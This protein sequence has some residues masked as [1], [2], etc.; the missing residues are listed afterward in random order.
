M[1]YFASPEI[2]PVVPRDTS[3]SMRSL[4]PYV[5]PCVSMAEF[6]HMM[7]SF[8]AEPT[9]CIK[10]LD[11]GR[12][13]RTSEKLTTLP[14]A[15]PK[16]IRPPEVVVYDDSEGRAGSVWS[17]SADIWA[18]GCTI[19]QIY[20]KTSYELISTWGS[21][22]DF[23]LRT[24]QLG[25]P[26][27]DAWPGI[28][29]T[30]S[31]HGNGTNNGDFCSRDEAWRNQE[32][33]SSSPL[34]GRKQAFIDLLKEMIVTNPDGRTPLADLLGH[35][36]FAITNSETP[37]PTKDVE[38]VRQ[39]NFFFP[40][41]PMTVSSHLLL[42]H[43]CCDAYPQFRCLSCRSSYSPFNASFFARRTAATASRRPNSYTA[44]FPTFFPRSARLDSTL[45]DRPS[46]RKTQKDPTI[47]TT[48]VELAL[49][50]T[51]DTPGTCIYVHHEK[52]SYVFGQV[53]EGTQRA[54]SCRKLHLGG[55]EHVFLSG[56]VRWSQMGGL[57]GYLLSVGGAIDSAKEARATMN[58]E[59]AEKGQKLLR[60]LRNEGV[61]VH[62]ADNLSHI[63]AS[64]RPTIFR[65][66]IDVRVI[67]FR[68]DPRAADSTLTAPDWEDESIRVWKI[69]VRRA[70]S[71][72]PTKRPRSDSASSGSCKP[73]SE[74]SDPSVAQWILEKIM[75]TGA[76][77]N[78]ML[79]SKSIDELKPDDDAIVVEGNR[80]RR[81]NGPFG[82][83]APKSFSGSAKAWV[84][85]DANSVHPKGDLIGIN[86]V[87]NGALP[88]TSYSETS[89]SYI[90]KCHDRRGKF[91]AQ[92]A[93]DLGVKP[94]SFKLLTAGET[95]TT[96]SGTVVTP[97]MVL[98][99]R[100]PG[101]GIAVADIS[102]RDFL[103]AFFERP[104]WTNAEIMAEVKTMYWVLG[105]GIVAD[106]KIQQYIKAHPDIKHVLCSPNTCPNMISNSSSA[107]TLAKLRRVDPD[108]F[109]F[110]A[111]DN[112]VDY[113][114]PD[115]VPSLELGRTGHRSQLMPRLL[116]D[117]GPVASFTDLQ[118][119][120]NAVDQE[121]IE[122]AQ[123]AKAKVTDPAFLARIERQEA[124]IPNRDAEITALGTGS[125]VPNKHRNV[126]GTLIRVPGIGSYLLDCGEG[127]LGQIKRLFGP[128][129]TAAVLRDLR[130]IVVS[131][132]HADHHLGMAS[133]IK[134]WYEQ[135]LADKSDALLAVSCID[136]YRAVL[137]EIAQ[138]E[139]I[140]FH[141]LRFPSCVGPHRDVTT[142]EQLG[143]L[144][145]PDAFGLRR[146]RRVPVPHCWRSYATE[147]ELV[148]GLRIAWSGDCR[149]SSQFARACRGA[150][151][152]VHE[153][154]FGDDK[155][156]HAK[157]K[158]HSTMSEALGVAREMQARRT[159]L[160][161]F[162]QR[163]GKAD[164]LQ[165]IIE[166][167]ARGEE[168]EQSV[169]LAH[170]LMRVKLG[171]FQ[172]AACYVPAIAQVLAKTATDA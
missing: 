60:Q 153:C 74:P 160:T 128:K 81:Y 43:V 94:Q 20:Y 166:G 171:D 136:R 146:I 24:V 55:T 33:D 9:M 2:I 138:V 32:A 157:A 158:N 112:T 59:R 167:D 111:F 69:P 45:G 85:P 98:G 152:L 162:S 142:A 27:P 70:R 155:Q 168:K 133:T 92:A 101:R 140:G 26:P 7:K 38:A 121:A 120:Y 11:F 47:M 93:K 13:H 102:S 67:E 118:L 63:L 23:I 134:A 154:T 163:Y 71:S 42:T 97:D 145:A 137:E 40:A 170:D 117:D 84:F 131:H 83:D 119:A 22:N 56:P 88:P 41:S 49:V 172:K 44:R 65:Q 161:H 75:F 164:A 51:S 36:F 151:L 159:L 141:R 90:M 123:K 25:G 28:W 95:V 156:D 127:T 99:E 82:V 64:A 3:T 17:K 115:N 147:F 19:Y 130:C 124:D 80:M 52:R 143:G 78:A 91:N 132:L 18:V 103:D 10:I 139:D 150:H 6:L 86:T 30:R 122:L 89:M 53:P 126:S 73:A 50:P 77:D 57:I 106:P 68:E 15:A 54:F 149:P 35:P 48:K 107:E 135:A 5:T 1:E 4:P 96:D 72:S 62:G 114:V 169:L 61:T 129:G 113:A 116:H 79:I 76:H 66:N 125:S 144:G 58:S 29:N 87:S 165:P 39:A 108:R 14:G 12:A 109:P 110:V 16:L 31:G 21:H 46:H 105:D 34:D 37:S 148:S 104:E 100:Q 8:P